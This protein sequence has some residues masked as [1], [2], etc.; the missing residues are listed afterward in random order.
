MRKVPGMALLVVAGVAIRALSIYPL[1][2]W[3]ADFD[4][5]L[6]GIRA[7]GIL[8]GHFPVY[9]T[10]RRLGALEG[11]L[12]AGS[13]AVFGVSRLSQSIVLMVAGSLLLVFFA[14]LVRSLLG[15][16]AATAAL[17]L[18]VLPP[19][20]F[21]FWSFR[22]NAYALT[23]LLACA[24]L[25]FADRLAR[26]AGR[27]TALLLGLAGGLA[28]W[29][30]LQTIA[31]LVPA[32]AWVLLLR[33]SVLRERR[34]LLPGA[35]G[36]V[37]GI[38]PLIVYNAV[39]RFGT[40]TFTLLRPAS[41]TSGVLE[42]LLFLS[43][44]NLPALF[45]GREPSAG[46]PALDAAAAVL[47]PF[48]IGVWTVA[49]LFAGMWVLVEAYGA[50]RA[51]AADRIPG[52][53]LLF[54]VGLMALLLTVFSSVGAERGQPVRY[55]LL[56]YFGAAA[57]AG[58]AFERARGGWRFLA[59]GVLGVVLVFNLIGLRPPGSPYREQLRKTGLAERRVLSL[60]KENRVEVVWGHVFWIYPLN[61]LSRGTIR[62][63][64]YQVAADHYR[65]GQRLP[66]GA[67]P[68]A[69]YSTIPGELEAWSARANLRGTL[70]DLDDG[71]FVF[72]PVPNPPS[73]EPLPETQAKLFAAVPPPR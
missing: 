15:R 39:T 27:W 33:P 61:F 70:H 32:A 50:W 72:L 16:T 71:Q 22:P 26:G 42:N 59:A 62:A 5:V 69:L 34:F 38:L 43:T 49:L 68:W 44:R 36:F 63:V 17:A 57:A 54:A 4:D 31:V 20:A 10:D 19:P 40:F 7:I 55:T 65:Y 64:P 12:H 56:A 53:T 3:D 41:G 73:L 18:L 37:T 30:S 9:L 23:L 66:K 58:I 45:T 51:R 1:Y 24:T 47:V 11:Y 14:L 52:A 60:L 29:N 2:K 21:L 25:Y 28:L 67:R 8:Q 35:A 46:I 13:F 6:T 48:V